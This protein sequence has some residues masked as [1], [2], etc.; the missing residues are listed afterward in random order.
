MSK[1]IEEKTTLLRQVEKSLT[2]CENYKVTK[3]DY[4]RDYWEGTHNLLIDVKKELL[5]PK[6]TSIDIMKM[7]I[8]ADRTTP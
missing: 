8:N 2:V 4:Y 1:G 5:K 6:T 7:I 3:P